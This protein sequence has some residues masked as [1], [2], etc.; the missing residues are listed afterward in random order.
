MIFSTYTKS[1]M[2]VGGLIMSLNIF[3]FILNFY[4]ASGAAV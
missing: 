1:E 4:A 2:F 3:S